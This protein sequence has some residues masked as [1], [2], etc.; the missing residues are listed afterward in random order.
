MVCGF[1]LH[2]SQ[3]CPEPCRP[4]LS[5]WR[6]PFSPSLPYAGWLSP[7]PYLHF[8]IHSDACLS[9]SVG[10]GAN[11]S[12][13]VVSPWA[14]GL[15]SWFCHALLFSCHLTTI[16]VL[17]LVWCIGVRWACRVQTKRSGRSVACRNPLG[18]RFNDGWIS[19]SVVVVVLYR[20]WSQGTDVLLS[21]LLTPWWFSFWLLECTSTRMKAVENL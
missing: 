1:I 5:P 15:L 10:M 7:P 8:V 9:E 6:N 11:E 20:P 2:P 19:A 14:S 4:L 21:V 3:S 13:Y 16:K 12:K 18:Q 17:V